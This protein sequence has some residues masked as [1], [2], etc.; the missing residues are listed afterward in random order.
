VTRW[1]AELRRF[2][3]PV[4]ASGPVLVGSANFTESTIIAEIYSQALAA[5]G[6]ESS[7]KLNIGSARCYI[8]ALQD[9]SIAVV[10]EY[11]GNLLGFVRP[12]HH[13]ESAEE[14]EAA[15]PDAPARRA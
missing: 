14:V 1:P 7:T 15:L 4:G 10:P 11:T 9:S 2:H 13:R 12:G 8:K 3:R 6:I 5:K